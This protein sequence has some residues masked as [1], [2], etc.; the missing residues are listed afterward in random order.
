MMIPADSGQFQDFSNCL[1][2]DLA[3][4]SESNPLGRVKLATIFG[5]R[6][7]C[8]EGTANKPRS[9]LNELYIL[10]R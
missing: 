2:R 1:T 6:V 10:T 4:K 9:V 7:Y 3:R 5:F 8:H